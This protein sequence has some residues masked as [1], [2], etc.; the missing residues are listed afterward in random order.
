MARVGRALIP[1]LSCQNCS[2]VF[3]CQ[4][5]RE[6]SQSYSSSY[7]ASQMSLSLGTM[8]VGCLRE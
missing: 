2:S 4:V 8:L 5:G 6:V 7:A 3:T 1:L